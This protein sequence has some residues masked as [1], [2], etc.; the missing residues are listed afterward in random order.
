MIETAHGFAD[1][2][3]ILRQGHRGIE[4]SV[5]TLIHLNGPEYG[6]TLNEG[7]RESLQAALRYLRETA[8]I[9][10]A[11]EEETLFPRLRRQQLNR[12]LPALARIE[13]L[14][15]EHVCADRSHADIDLLGRIWLRRGALP[16]DEASRMSKL[17]R[18]L[19]DLYRHHIAIEEDEIFPAV[20]TFAAS[21]IREI[22]DEMAARRKV[23]KS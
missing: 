7:D 10:T 13:S 8:P 16:S 11:D 19:R 3:G 18:R 6:A 1:P 2:I 12:A 21:T 15:E 23:R 4:A 9:H 22:A 5:A 14:E 17:T 20:S